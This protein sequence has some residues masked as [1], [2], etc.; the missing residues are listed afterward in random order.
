MLFV[1]LNQSLI[2]IL[3]KISRNLEKI[4]YQKNMLKKQIISGDLLEIILYRLA[5]QL[6]E[7][8]QDFSN[9]ILIGLQPK[10][11]ILAQALQ[12]KIQEITQ[13]T[14]TLGYLDATFFRDDFRQPNLAPLR[15]NATKITENLEG[16]KVILVD[17]VLYTGRSV[18]SALD[19]LG[20]FG[21]PAKIELLVLVNRLY[22]RDLPIEPHYVGKEVIT[23]QSQRVLVAWKNPQE[24]IFENTIFLVEETKD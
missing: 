5:H 18:R 21:R 10:G 24:N 4:F 1:C 19:A 13:K 23:L 11:V 6:F 22:T 20:S 15:A 2:F 17:D 16:K 3:E 14:I 7:N 8:H 12:H 9:T